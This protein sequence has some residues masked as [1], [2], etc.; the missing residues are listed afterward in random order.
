M[1]IHDFSDGSAPATTADK[2]LWAMHGVDDADLVSYQAHYSQVNPWLRDP[3]LLPV[4]RA[5]T[6]EML[7][8]ADLLQRSEFYSDWLRPQDLAHSMGTMVDMRSHRGLSMT[9]LRSGEVGE[10]QP[11]ELVAFQNLIPHLQRAL[12]LHQRL[13]VAESKVSELEETLS[14]LPTGVL[15]LDSLAR[16]RS[17]NRSA[18]ILLQQGCGLSLDRHH[19][20]VAATAAQTTVLDVELRS[21]LQ[22]VRQKVGTMPRGGMIRFRGAAGS[23]HAQITG[24][25]R[26]PHDDAPGKAVAAV[27]L[28]SADIRPADLAASVQQQLR[29]TRAEARLACAL[30][31]GQSLAE[32]AEE[33]GL[34]ISTVRTQLRSAAQRVGVRRQAELVR[35]VLT[36]VLLPQ[37][38]LP[39][40]ESPFPDEPLPGR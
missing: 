26:D 5:V 11:Q 40:D 39:G 38:S 10:F 13:A 31:L 30:A 33:R 22:P 19:H 36:D 1:F 32:Y 15:T 7:Y 21:V 3:R 28:S 37:R 35:V 6:S 9:M 12:E 20:L 14:L 23:L 34:G 16:V 24:L 8:P 4:S 18:Q 2:W 27:F 25:P 29:L 17:M